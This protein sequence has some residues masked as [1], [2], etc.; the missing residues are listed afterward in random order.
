MRRLVFLLLLLVPGTLWAQGLKGLGLPGG[1]HKTDP[2]VMAFE[3]E[4]LNKI[5]VLRQKKKLAALKMDSRVRGFA[6]REAEL[7]ATGDPTAKSIKDRIKG[8]GLAPYGFQMQYAF[9]ATSARV[10]KDLQKNRAMEQALIGEF[11]RVG[12][13]AFWVPIEEPYFQV[14]VLLPRDPD[15]MAGEPGLSPA[16]TNKVM[17]AAMPR[18]KKCFD[19]ALKSNPNLRGEVLLQ[20][21]IGK[22]GTVESVKE[23][24]GLGAPAFDVCAME[25]VKG[26]QFP[27]PYKGKP[28]TLNHPMRFSPPQGDRRL[29]KLTT[30]Q[31]KGTF[32]RVSIRFRKCYDE[33]VKKKPELKGTIELALTVRRDGGL[34]DLR[35]I[36]DDIEDEPLNACVLKVARELHFPR[37]KHDGEVDLTYPLRFDP[38]E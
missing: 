30:T 33:R 34:K 22:A 28:V 4:L 35:V 15:P 20:L 5:N 21:V 24:K 32:S 17:H 3:A 37:P 8:R 23:I 12:I 27:K 29:G 14:L 36:S 31:I 2:K 11:V 19:K 9:G 38:H 25:I 6:R 16:Q 10:L 18:I 7:A 1:L 13:G 26:L